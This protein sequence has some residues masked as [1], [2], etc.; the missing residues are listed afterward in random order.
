MSQVVFVLFFTA[1]GAIAA[2]LAVRAGAGSPV[3]R[4]LAG[5]FLVVLAANLGFHLW[6][7][8]AA[9]PA[10]AGR[11]AAITVV[12]VLAGLAYLGLLRAIRRAAGRKDGE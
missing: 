8:I 7:A 9:D 12:I 11:L 2:L 1:A 3:I 5:V 6:P 4:W 10:G